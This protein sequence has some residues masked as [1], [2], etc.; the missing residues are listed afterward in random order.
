MQTTIDLTLAPN[1]KYRRV[2][3][4]VGAADADETPADQ[5]DYEDWPAE[6]REA[7]NDY[8]ELLDNAWTPSE[9]DDVDESDLDVLSWDDLSPA[10]DPDLLAKIAT[11]FEGMTAA[12]PSDRL[13]AKC[14]LLDVEIYVDAQL[15]AREELR[16][17][18]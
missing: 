13:H 10:S 9:S 1:D 17:A 2:I 16:S 15:A 3:G 12:E 5:D 8:Q 11:Y 14:R 6:H 4:D 7:A 18:G